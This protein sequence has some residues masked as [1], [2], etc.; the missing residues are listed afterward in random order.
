[1]FIVS[2]PGDENNLHDS[3]KHCLCFGGENPKSKGKRLSGAWMFYGDTRTI[4]WWLQVGKGFTV[5]ILPVQVIETRPLHRRGSPA[6]TNA[7]ERST[8]DAPGNVEGEKLL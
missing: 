3:V 7:N 2:K 4:W 1:M 6:A 8:K 5:G